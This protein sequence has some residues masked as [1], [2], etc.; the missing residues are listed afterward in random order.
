MARW[1]TGEITTRRDDSEENK[2]YRCRR[3]GLALFYRVTRNE[4]REWSTYVCLRLPVLFVCC[5]WEEKIEIWMGR[6][7]E[8]RCLLVVFIL[9]SDDEEQEEEEEEE[10]KKKKKKWW[11]W[12]WTTT[13]WQQQQQPVL[14]FCFVFNSKHLVSWRTYKRSIKVHPSVTVFMLII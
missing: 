7:G 10:N 13:S 1:Q 9:S 12:W 5:C 2:C 8:G 14:F 3:N 11:W 4:R 6:G